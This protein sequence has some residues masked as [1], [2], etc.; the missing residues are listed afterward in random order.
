VIGL[1]TLAVLACVGLTVAAVLGFVFFLMKIVLWA[2]FFP[3]RLLFKLLW[4]PVG[5]AFGAVGMGLGLAALP[6]LLL[7]LGGVLVFGII[8]AIISLLIP[9]IPFV[10]LG[11]LLW[12]LF[13]RSPATA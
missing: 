2:V 8:A 1:F 11:L 4:L 3:L 12:S 6:L 5:L 9:A 10:L 7:V 13:R